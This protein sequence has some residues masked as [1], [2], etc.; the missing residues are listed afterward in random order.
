MLCHIFCLKKPIENFIPAFFCF[1][2][3]YSVLVHES[4][5]LESHREAEKENTRKGGESDSAFRV[6]VSDITRR[7]TGIL[8]L[9]T[10]Y[11]TLMTKNCGMLDSC[12]KEIDSFWSANQVQARGRKVVSRQE[13]A[14]HLD[15]HLDDYRRIP[16]GRKVGCREGR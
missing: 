1:V 2:S 6:Q 12:D 15:P 9:F 13:W 11:P 5:K 4:F 3:L 16:A 14:N 10:S 8:V 7:Q